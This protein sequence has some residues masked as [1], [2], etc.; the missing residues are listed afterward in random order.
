MR[1]VVFR[2]LVVI[3]VFVAIFI[4]DVLPELIKDKKNKSKDENLNKV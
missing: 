4:G 3:F 2:V 1:K